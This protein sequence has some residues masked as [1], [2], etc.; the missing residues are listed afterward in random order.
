MA[1]RLQRLRPL[2]C[3]PELRRVSLSFF[4]DPVTEL[5]APLVA[6]PG[7]HRVG[8]LLAERKPPFNYYEISNDMIDG[9][10]IRQGFATLV[11]NDGPE[12]DDGPQS[13]TASRYPLLEGWRASAFNL[14]SVTVT[15]Q[16]PTQPA[17]VAACEPI[18]LTPV[19]R[20]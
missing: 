16:H 20:P 12:V 2:R 19:G 9:L 14:L 17:F 3:L 4:I 6:I 8:L 15:C 5:S 13:G 18:L 7:S 11:A 10:L 1:S